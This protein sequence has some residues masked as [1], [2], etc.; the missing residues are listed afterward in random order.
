MNYTCHSG[1]CPGADMNW[2]NEGNKY[3]V[4]TI[5]YSFFNHVQEGKNQKILTLTELEEGAEHVLIAEM[6]LNRR[7]Q[8]LN[9][10]YVL[11]LLCRNWYQVKNSTSIFA[12]GTFINKN[13]NIVNGGT[14]WAVQMGIDNKKDV[15]LFEQEIGKWFMFDYYLHPFRFKE[16]NAIPALTENF[17]GIGTR[18]I[19]VDGINAIK[20]I[21]KYN[22]PQ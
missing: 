1:G 7:L 3:G 21:Y 6:S 16:F 12:I 13:H 2:E 19:N 4:K 20:E 18:K 22:M 15:Y 17:A 9:S 10:A 14:G 8:N 11:N 5:A